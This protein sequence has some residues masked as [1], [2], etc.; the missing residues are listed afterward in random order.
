M[1]VFQWVFQRGFQ[2]ARKEMAKLGARASRSNEIVEIA[3]V[4]RCVQNALSAAD[5][6][7]ASRPVFFGSQ[8]H[9]IQ[10]IRFVQQQIVR[11]RRGRQ[12]RPP[13]EVCSVTGHFSDGY[14]APRALS[15]KAVFV[16]SSRSLFLQRQNMCA[17]KT[18]R[19]LLFVCVHVCVVECYFACGRTCVQVRAPR[20]A[21]RLPLC[22]LSLLV[23][24]DLD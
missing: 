14:Q 20:H 6:R 5:G 1:C 9:L 8:T 18:A 2:N 24:G 17:R 23:Q 19:S 7:T 15:K 11:R 4:S 13:V 10:T 3:A 16:A 22:L 21:C 12:T